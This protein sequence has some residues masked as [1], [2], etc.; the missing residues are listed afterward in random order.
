MA[1]QRRASFT[2]AEITRAIKGAQAAGID[3]ARV[4]IDRQTGL[5][6]I[7]PDGKASTAANPWDEA[8]R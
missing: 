7:V 6:V 3:P 1:N 8:L 5:I 4:E 2:Q